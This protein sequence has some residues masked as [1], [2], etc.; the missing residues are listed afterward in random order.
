MARLRAKI[1]G[2]AAIDR[3][4][5]QIR[6][7]LDGLNDRIQETAV[8]I[9]EHAAGKGNGDVSRALTLCQA[10][11][12]KRTLNVNYLVGYFAYFAGTNVNLRKPSVSL[13]SKD[14]KKQRGFDVDGARAN[15]WFE[16]VDAEGKRVFWYAGPEPEAYVPDGIGDIAERM[17]RFVK[18][19]AETLDGEKEVNGK[20]VPLVQLSQADRT[21]LDAALGFIDRI[22]AT[23]ARHENVQALT[24]QLQKATEEAGQDKE[25]LEVLHID[26]PKEM[27]VA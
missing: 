12:S 25:V 22:A 11:A 16:A 15:K 3:S 5:A 24:E 6:G 8:A 10:I 7:N 26:E 21:A 17:Q 27:A 14:S 9:V 13:F 18:R 2:L 23:L 19:T 20:K 4:I 1:E